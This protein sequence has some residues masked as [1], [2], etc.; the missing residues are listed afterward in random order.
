MYNFVQKLLGSEDADIID[1]YEA[2]DMSLPGMFAYRSILDGNTPKEIP[3]L[4]DKKER[5]KWRNDTACTDPNVA[6]D[7]LLPTCAT[8][9]PDIDD[10]V[11]ENMYNKWQADLKSDDGYSHLAFTQGEIKRKDK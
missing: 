10:K 11:Y 8:G 5:D 4:R 7:M 6:G 2:L 1:V 9:T 3:N